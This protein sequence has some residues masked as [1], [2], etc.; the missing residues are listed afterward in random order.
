[1]DTV[2]LAI[3]EEKERF[4]KERMSEKDKGKRLLYLFQEAL[5]PG[6]NG[7]I[8]ESKDKR[9]NVKL[10]GSSRTFWDG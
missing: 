3:K 9:D 5:M 2:E 10:K 7:M 8:L 1:M 6:I 4:E